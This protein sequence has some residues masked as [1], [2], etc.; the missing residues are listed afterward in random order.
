MGQISVNNLRICT[1]IVHNILIL[2]FVLQLVVVKYAHLLRII[3]FKQIINTY[4]LTFLYFKYLPTY[5]YVIVCTYYLVE[6]VFIGMRSFEVGGQDHLPMQ[7]V[8][9]IFHQVFAVID[10]IF[11]FI[12]VIVQSKRL[13]TQFCFHLYFNRTI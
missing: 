9:S 3:G 12:C 6:R 7:L 2:Q 4:I 11:F 10:A 1:Y 8:G 5:V 13:L